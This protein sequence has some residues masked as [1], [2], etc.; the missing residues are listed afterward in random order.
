MTFISRRV[1]VS[2][3][4][5]RRAP[6]CSPRFHFKPVSLVFVVLQGN[7]TFSCSD[8]QLVAATFLSSSSSFLSLPATAVAS[9][10][11]ASQGFSVR[12]Q[13]RTWNPDGLLLW[14]RLSAPEPHRLE[15]TISSS[16]IR[17]TL[18]TSSSPHTSSSTQHTSEV[19]T[20][21]GAKP[22]THTHTRTRTHVCAHTEYL[23]FSLET[24]TAVYKCNS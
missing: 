17:L 3:P 9:G 20:G 22:H 24:R 6:T 23:L 5:D 16:R 21:E 11:A 2:L 7:V 4:R 13:F 19:S 18:L 14:T 12:F 8:P 15:L 1:T 10:A